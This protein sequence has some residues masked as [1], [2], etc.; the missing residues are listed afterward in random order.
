MG[1]NVTGVCGGE[2]KKQLSE[3]IAMNFFLASEILSLP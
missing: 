1:M 2:L 3:N